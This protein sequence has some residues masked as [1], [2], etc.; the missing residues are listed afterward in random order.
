MK[1]STGPKPP[2]MVK[3]P[4]CKG[5]GI[6]TIES[7]TLSLGKPVEIAFTKIR[8]ITCNGA[9]VITQKQMKAIEREAA[10]WCACKTPD[11]ENCTFCDDGECADCRKHHYH[12]GSC[13]KICQVG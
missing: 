8:C 9:A 3:C 2:K 4:T 11:L 12:C 5:A 10:L 6:Q 7:R 13:K 1:I